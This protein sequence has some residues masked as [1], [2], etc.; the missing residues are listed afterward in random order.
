MGILS[1]AI[2][3]ESQGVRNVNRI[4]KLLGRRGVMTVTLVA[5]PDELAAASPAVDALL[6]D[7]R[8]RPGNRYAEFI[9]GKDKV[10]QYGLTALVVGGAGAA[11][12]KSGLL[13]KFWKQIAIGLA[14]LG[15]GI[16][17]VFFSGRSAQ[18]DPEKPIT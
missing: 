9:P 7:Y 3:G 14:A 2:M 1:W 15:A 18:H 13:A 12:L 4:I 5:A 10:A 8:Y 16:K 11:L 17:R 6:G